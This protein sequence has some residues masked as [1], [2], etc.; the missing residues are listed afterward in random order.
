MS[1]PLSQDRTARGAA[2]S[3]GRLAAVALWALLGLGAAGCAGGAEAGSGPQEAETGTPGRLDPDPLVAVRAAAQNTAAAG[4][5]VTSTELVMNSGGEEVTVTGEGEYDFERRLGD[6]TVVVPEGASAIGGG[7]AA[8]GAGAQ[9]ASRTMAEL[10]APDALYMQGGADVPE[11]HWVRVNVLQLSDG[12]LISGG[13][14]DPYTAAQVLLGVQEAELVGTETLGGVRVHHFKGVSDLARAAEI[15]D[16]PTSDALRQASLNL[17]SARI[18]F[19][20]YLDDQGRMHK[21]VQRLAFAAAPA[22][23]GQE[24]AD[25]EVEVTTTTLLSEFGAPVDVAMPASD[26]I[27]EPGAVE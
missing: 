5:A 26:L 17:S 8:A 10:F 24:P 4:S 11:G 27:H 12:N 9:G 25:T 19:D 15:A 1:Y 2:P 20:V 14:T 13:G 6:L 16:A 23:D 3:A 18:P 7:E 22:E 21:V